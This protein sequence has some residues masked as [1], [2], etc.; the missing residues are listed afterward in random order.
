MRLTVFILLAA[1][2][3][4][5]APALSADTAGELSKTRRRSGAYLGLRVITGQ[6][7]FKSDT[8]ESDILLNALPAVV[9]GIDLWPE[10]HIG[11]YADLH[12]GTGST[13]SDLGG[14]DVDL[15]TTEY[16]VGGRYRFFM[17]PEATAVALGIGLG[18]HGFEQSVRDQRPSILLDRSIIG[19]QLSMFATLP[20]M[21]GRLWL[22][23]SAEFQLPFFV[24]E[25]PN[26]SGDPK[27]FVGYGARL[28][29]VFA[30]TGPWSVQLD[31]EYHQ[32]Q[33][34][35]AGLATRGAGTQD[36]AATDHFMKYGLSARYVGF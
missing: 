3:V 18:V 7:K 28:E 31:L 36:G 4:T 25:S 14:Y 8:V 33:V 11:L 5:N 20:L 32:R 13:I 23:G 12:V 10:E 22:R 17:G 27:S 6:L 30:V 21:Q 24:R 29:S 2:S 16:R 9:G 26:D 1:L 19:P 15:N 34:D 35:F